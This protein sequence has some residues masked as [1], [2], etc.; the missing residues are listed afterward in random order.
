[1][2]DKLRELVAQKHM[3]DYQYSLQSALRLWL[4]AHIPLSDLAAH[5]PEE[6]EKIAAYRSFAVVR[7]PRA[8]FLSAIFQ[9]LREFKHLNQSAMTE[10]RVEEEAIE[11]YKNSKEMHEAFDRLALKRNAR[12]KNQIRQK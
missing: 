1:M 4:F 5:F 12:Q 2:L 7:D 3:L 11:E 8:R 6:Y 9:R 10:R